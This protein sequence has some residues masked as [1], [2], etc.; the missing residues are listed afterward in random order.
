MSGNVCY[1]ANSAMEFNGGTQVR[2]RP[3][4]TVALPTHYTHTHTH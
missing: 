1:G 2:G 3:T 4:V